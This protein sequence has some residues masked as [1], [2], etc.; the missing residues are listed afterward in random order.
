MFINHET[1]VVIYILF[2]NVKIFKKTFKFM[3]AINNKSLQ[4]IYVLFFSFR[5]IDESM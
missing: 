5:Y 2:V 4:I 1:T 3:K